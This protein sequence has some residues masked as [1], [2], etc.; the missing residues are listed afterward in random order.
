MNVLYCGTGW[1]PLVEHVARRLPA[2]STIEIW[3]RAEPLIRAVG[4]IHVILPSNAP[5][6]A[7]VFNA[8]SNLRLIQQPAAGIDGIDLDTARERGVPV[9]NAPGGNHISVAETA[10]FL[11]LALARRLPLAQKAFAERQLGVP[12]GNELFGKTLGI[13]GMG[14]SGQALAE[15]AGALGLTILS[16]TSASSRAEWRELLASSDIISL[17]CPLTESTRGLL[18]RGAFA[19]MKP[20][21]LVINC[22]RGPVIDRD[23]LE[24]ALE[25]GQVGGAGLD[26]LWSEPW[27]P[28]EPLFH[29]DDVVAL[30]HVAGSSEQSFERIAAITCDNIARVARGD[31]PLY[32]VA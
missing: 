12:P 14:R 1:L 7:A 32:R 13:V 9:C 15:R 25:S 26:V 28:T 4:D 31:E 20:G 16:V 3:N 11:I 8:A 19:A 5:I 10:L 30:P 24:R 21:V 2:G 17:H 27:D 6:D 18:D 22:A 29:R 23:A